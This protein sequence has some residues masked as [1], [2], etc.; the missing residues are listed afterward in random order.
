VSTHVNMHEDI[1]RSVEVKGSSDR[2]FGLTLAGVST[3]VALWPLLDRNPVRLWALALALGW[4]VL[5]VS[6]PTVLHRLNRAWMRLGLLLAR[7]TT[8]ILM[9]AV[10][11][12]VVTPTGL[13]RRA[14]GA[15]AMRLGFDE[16]AKS[17][18]IPRDPKG[19]TPE[20]MS[21]QY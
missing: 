17:Y 3:I 14:F 18:W 19:P 12:A 4:L 15:N 6:R 8:P 10:F 2:V 16:T 13:L 5:A 9:G 20:S 21:R 11:F 7:V 1:T